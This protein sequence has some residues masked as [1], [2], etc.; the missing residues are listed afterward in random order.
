MAVWSLTPYLIL[1]D[2]AAALAFYASAFDAQEVTRLTAPDDGRVVHAEILLH[3]AKVY[4]SDDFGHDIGPG[5]GISL[6]L[7]V[8]DADKILAQAAAAGAKVTMPV[9]ETFWGARHGR[10]Q[11]PLG[12]GWSVSTQ[13]RI[14]SEAEMKAAVA[15]WAAKQ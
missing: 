15:E 9:E 2:A 5:G 12:I 10:F 3:G 8:P 6:H 13:V 1:P 7:E 4:L 11:D 14:L